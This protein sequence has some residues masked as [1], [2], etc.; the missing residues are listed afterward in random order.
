MAAHET[1]MSCED[2]LKVFIRN[3]LM[4]IAKDLRDYGIL[5]KE[6]YRSATDTKS[7]ERTID[8]AHEVFMKLTDAVEEDEDK[9][10]VFI[11]YLRNKKHVKMLEKLN[12]EYL[13]QKKAKGCE[14][15][16]VDDTKFKIKDQRLEARSA[17]I[18]GM[19]LW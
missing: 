15:Y 4:E 7:R 19:K 12:T 13:R 8:R 2:D 9:Y 5:D 18:Q 6:S 16:E 3:H 1:L 11:E 14:N 10:E 17:H